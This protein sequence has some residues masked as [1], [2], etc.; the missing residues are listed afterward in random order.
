MDCGGCEITPDAVID[1]VK[2]A[3]NS[4]G[5]QLY[6]FRIHVWDPNNE[7]SNAVITSAQGTIVSVGPYSQGP[8]NGQVK[9]IV[10]L[11]DPGSN[12]GPFC[13]NVSFPGTQFCNVHV[14]STFPKCECALSNVD[15]TYPSCIR[16]NQ[17]FCVIVEFDY[18]GPLNI[19][20]NFFVD[21]TNSDPGFV[22]VGTFPAN[23]T[24]MIGQNTIIACF[25]YTGTCD[26]TMLFFDA[27]LPGLESCKIWEMH[28]FQCCD[29]DQGGGKKER[30][31]TEDTKDPKENW[32]NVFPNPAS[33]VIYLNLDLDAPANEVDIAL[34][35]LTGRRV[36]VWE[37]SALPAGQ[38][39]LRWNI[40]QQLEMG[41]YLLH[42]K[43][44]D[45]QYTQKVLLSQ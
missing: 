15:V 1:Y 13:L 3:T 4:N 35:D 6:E 26:G 34:Y 38:Q 43:V 2:C 37:G 7:I 20:V 17:T 8:P 14:C 18:T 23:P 41:H 45:K 36:L 5:D 31:T 33:D 44:G 28:E 42:L 39:Q 21:N 30:L 27:V 12:T 40:G 10:G 29:D 19:P 25:T 9:R 11:I 16:P 22:L 32:V 24:A